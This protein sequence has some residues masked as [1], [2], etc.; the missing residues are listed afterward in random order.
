MNSRSFSLSQ[1]A[2]NIGEDALA[3]LLFANTPSYLFKQMLRSGLPEE[4]LTRLNRT[5]LEKLVSDI[6]MASPPP[7]EHLACL[8]A[9]IIALGSL[10]LSPKICGRAEG[11]PWLNEVTALTKAHFDSALSVGRTP[12]DSGWVKTRPIDNSRS[13]GASQEIAFPGWSISNDQV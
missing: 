1:A 6:A 11:I 10:G 8:Y 2:D 7:A 5:E 12:V 13:A 4:L 3:A 9:A